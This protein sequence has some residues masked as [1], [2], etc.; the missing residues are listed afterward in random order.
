VLKVSRPFKNAA[1]SALGAPWNPYLG[2]DY[3]KNSFKILSSLSFW[4][5]A[6]K[7]CIWEEEAKKNTAINKKRLVD[8]LFCKYWTLL[9]TLGD[10]WIHIGL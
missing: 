10:Y 7:K 1:E 4:E 5:K 6:K 3:E 8:K 2:F 9:D